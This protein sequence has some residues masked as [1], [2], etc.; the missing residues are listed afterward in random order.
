MVRQKPGLAIIKQIWDPRHMFRQ[1]KED[2]HGW[3][4]EST[5]VV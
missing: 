5:P 2:D 1:K 4:L 3:D